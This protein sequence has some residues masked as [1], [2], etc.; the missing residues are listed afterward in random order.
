MTPQEG[1]KHFST[2][3]VH[4]G[5]EPDQHG[6]VIPP[7]SLA[8]T[9]SQTAPACP[10]GAFDYSRSGNPTR[11]AYETA[12]AAVEDAKYAF[13]FSSGLGT[14]ST[15]T[16]LLKSGDHMLC[17]EDVYGGS[18][19]YIYRIARNFGISP[20]FIDCTQLD[21]LRNSLKPNTKM[22]WLET[23]TN[24]T[25]RL[26]D[27]EECCNII[28]AFNPEIIIV[29]DNTFM[30][31]YFQ[32]PLDLGATIVMHSITK[33]M[34]GHSDVVMGCC[35][36]N[37]PVLAEQIR[38]LQY[39]VGSVPSPF[40]CFLANRGLKTLP[41]RMKQHAINAMAVAKYLETSPYVDKVIY[42]GLP[43]H[44]QHSIANKQ[45]TGYGGMV[46]FIIKGDI[47]NAKEFLQS[48]KCFT[49]A[50]SLGSIES[51]AELPGLMT[52]ASMPE[53]MRV[54]LGITDTLLRLSVGIEETEDL[55]EDLEQSLRKSHK[56]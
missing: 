36:L 9:F 54:H 3:A 50:E 17:M 43:S 51:L 13:T 46:S 55:I 31:S 45:M 56:C 35:M 14:L 26:L 33:Y 25:L 53:E 28:R 37:D 52:H 39:S 42:P 44:P 4:A 7:I 23:P 40:D 1:F 12:L 5:Q 15:L 2:V 47:E 21:I 11:L 48:L 10:K 32:R 22:V 27:I 49:L 24:P 34:N 41:L 19:R 18:Y 20:E 30:S 8:T 29:V 16:H 6:A 38:F